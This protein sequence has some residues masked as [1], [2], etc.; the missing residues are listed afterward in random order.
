MQ[1]TYLSHIPANPNP[2]TKAIFML[3]GVG[4][5]ERDLFAL[6]EHFEDSYIFSLR[7]PFVRDADSYAWY[8]VDFSTGKTVYDFRNVKESIHILME[9][10]ESI[11]KEF[12]ILPEN[13]YLL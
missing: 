7:G 6:K 12:H 4:S 8:P 2:E 3:H 1:L 10:V 5:N 11:Q 13:T 9:T